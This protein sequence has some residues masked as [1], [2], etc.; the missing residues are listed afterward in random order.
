MCCRIMAALIC[1]GIRGQE[2]ADAMAAAGTAV[3]LLV[4]YFEGTAAKKGTSFHC[5]EA[6]A[7]HITMCDA[8]IML[9]L[10]L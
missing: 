9:M 5:V 8:R 6:S 10:R 7:A 3:R 4:G 1:D 2:G